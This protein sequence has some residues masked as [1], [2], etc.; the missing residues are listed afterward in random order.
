MHEPTRPANATAASATAVSARLS[1]SGGLGGDWAAPRRPFDNLHAPG[2]LPARSGAA[3]VAG[4][5]AS[6]PLPPGPGPRGCR[7]SGLLHAERAEERTERRLAALAFLDVASYSRLMGADEAATLRR[8]LSLRD[9]V[10]EP[11]VAGWRGCVVDRAGD[12]LFLEFRSVLDAV[13]WAFDVQAAMAS[14]PAA[15]AEAPPL[16]ARVAVHLGDVLGAADGG[17]HGDR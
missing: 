11:R 14:A 12:G 5:P 8:R 15:V 6:E 1:P 17:V 7:A 4:P 16:L 9:G 13:R 10:V 3:F 2:F